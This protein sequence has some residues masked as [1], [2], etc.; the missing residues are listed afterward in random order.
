MIFAVRLLP[1]AHHRVWWPKR[2]MGATPATMRQEPDWNDTL[3]TLPNYNENA[4]PDD[5]AD[6]VSATGMQNWMGMAKASTGV[7]FPGSQVTSEGVSDGL[8]NTYMAGEKYLPPD[9]YSNGQDGGDNENAF[10]GFNADIGRW[11]GPGALVPSPDTPGLSNN[12]IYGS[13]I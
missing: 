7:M 1:A 10:M 11:G 3:S 13:A 5:Y 9:D 4:G 6:G 12:N 2:I 8:S